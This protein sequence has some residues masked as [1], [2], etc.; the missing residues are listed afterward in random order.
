MYC[1]PSGFQNVLDQR[2]EQSL[3]VLFFLTNYCWI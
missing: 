2:A 3:S 1:I